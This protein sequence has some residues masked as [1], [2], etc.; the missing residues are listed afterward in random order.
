MSL[1]EVLVGMAIMMP[2]TLAAATG[3]MVTVTASDSAQT[4]QELEIALT[5]A[6]ENLK[7][8]PYLE[9][10]TA[11]QYA[12]LYRTWVPPLA[13]G[14]VDG[15][16]TTSPEISAVEYWSRTKAGYTGACADDGAQR[17]TVTVSAEGATATG[18]VVKR[19]EAASVRGE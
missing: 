13:P 11:E 8:M 18:T 9:C 10:G 5:T 4:H 6:T 7:A 17:F 15:V 1:I 3:L 16:Q 2:L 19:N 14:V 12:A